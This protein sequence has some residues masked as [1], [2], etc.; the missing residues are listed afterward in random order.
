MHKLESA[1]EEYVD[2][3]VKDDELIG[4]LKDFKQNY[5][6]EAVRNVI[7]KMFVLDAH[8]RPP[9]RS[10]TSYKEPTN[11]ADLAQIPL[12]ENCQSAKLIRTL[13]HL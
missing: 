6:L 11:I 4:S 12:K 9:D 7:S 8:T 2:T 13:S 3:Y 5:C 1:P 10:T